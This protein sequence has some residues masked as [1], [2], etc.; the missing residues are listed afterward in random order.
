MWPEC[1]DARHEQPGREEDPARV[2][3]NV[4]NRQFAI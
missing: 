2:D 1:F 4:L 3:A